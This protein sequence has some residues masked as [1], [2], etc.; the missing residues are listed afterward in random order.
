MELG[1]AVADGGISFRIRGQDREDDFLVVITG[2]RAHQK[3]VGLIVAVLGVVDALG[4]FLE[5]VAEAILGGQ[6]VA[7]RKHHH[8]THVQ[9]R[10]IA[11]SAHLLNIGVV[12][13]LH[14]GLEH[15]VRHHRLGHFNLGELLG[16]VAVGANDLAGGFPGTVVVLLSPEGIGPAGL[17]ANQ[18]ANGEEQGAEQQREGA[19]H[20]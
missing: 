18:Q 5:F 20:R 7:V 8:S 2:Q 6:G 3:D 16:E 1:F 10:A 19:A 17:G 9:A 4:L 14:H 13:N 15:R 11:V 12:G